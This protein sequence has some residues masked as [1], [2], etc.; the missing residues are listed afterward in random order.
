MKKKIVCAI[1]FEVGAEVPTSMWVT[2]CGDSR[3]AARAAA[4]AKLPLEASASYL[5]YTYYNGEVE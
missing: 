1:T 2:G 3:E 4:E 5:H